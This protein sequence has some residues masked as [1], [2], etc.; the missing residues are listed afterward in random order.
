MARKKGGAELSRGRRERRE[1]ERVTSARMTEAMDGGGEERA[2]EW[3]KDS[4][5]KRRN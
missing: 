3:R 4:G 2:A 5:E 1:R